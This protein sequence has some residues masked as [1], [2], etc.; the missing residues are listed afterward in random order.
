MPDWLVLLCALTLLAFVVSIYV[1]DAYKSGWRARIGLM[2]LRFVSVALLCVM[3][4]ELTL[5]VDRTGLPFVAVMIDQSASMSLEDQYEGDTA[6]AV[7]ELLKSQSKADRSRLGLAK[8][9]LSREDGDFLKQLVER[10]KIRV[11]QFSETA[12]LVGNNEYIRTD[13]IAELLPA[14]DKLSAAGPQTRPNPSIQKVLSDFR[15]TPPSAIVLISDGI[16]STNEADKLSVA[17]QA[18]RRDAIPIYTIAIGSEEPARDLNLYDTVVDEVAFVDDPITFTAKIKGFGFKT[19]NVEVSLREKKSDR[20]LKF[21]SVSVKGTGE[22]ETVEVTFVPDEPGEYEFVLQAASLPREANIVN[23][24]NTR[25]V[26]VREGRIRVLLIDSAPRWE[27]RELKNLLEREKTVELHTVLQDADPEYSRQDKTAQPLDGRF[28]VKRD[29]LFAYDVIIFGDVDSK[30][31]STG[32]MENLRDFVREAGG[33]LMMIAGPSHNPAQYRGTVLETLL[34]ID[35]AGARIP[36]I[37]TPI[38]DSFHPEL[39]LQGRKGSMIFRFAESE[40]KSQDVWNTLPDLYW[41]VEA[42]KRKPGTVVFAQHP[43]RS[44]SDGKFPVILMLRYGAGKV[45]FHA[46]DELWRW[47][48]RAGDLYYGRYWIQAIRYL[49]R[50]RL[51]GKSK[52]LDFDADRDE[53]DQ[54]DTVHLRVRFLNE[55]HMPDDDNGVKIV[56]ERQ[57]GGREEVG[58]HRLP[59]VPTVF[60]GQMRRV[61]EGS[62]HAWVAQPS[63]NAA[64]QSIDFRVEP[65]RK[66]ISNRSLDRAE[67]TAT[68]KLTRGKFYTLDTVKNLPKDIPPGDPIPIESE[69]PIPLWN[70]WEILLLF[71]TSLT[72]EWLIRKRLRLV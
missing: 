20:P 70:R 40:Q 25:H 22:P 14:I 52:N 10:H 59:Q 28:P 51:L 42:P 37:G 16:T 44:G 41:M 60:E 72:A 32:V 69:D 57:G 31:L 43:L 11:Y 58:L 30:F 61:R 33:G 24:A 2:G 35:L 49:S 54:G 63:F 50:T 34:P 21:S 39:T 56:V 38:L 27:Y 53:Y 62:Y 7:V 26:S 65:P 67:L 5:S 1:R 66:E 15:G 6:K 71:A 64:P 8:S 68:A 12:V 47:R 19:R 46:T 17:A 48:F 13:K 29:Q 36:S 9:L 23:N 45:V 3:L 18:A 4:T 55:E